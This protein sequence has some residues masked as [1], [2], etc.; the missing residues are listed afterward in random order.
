MIRLRERFWPEGELVSA[1]AGCSY[2]GLVSTLGSRLFGLYMRNA[3][4]ARL[5]GKRVAW[6]RMGRHETLIH[7]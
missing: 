1:P 5:C 4:R 3:G 2:I 6:F 7:S